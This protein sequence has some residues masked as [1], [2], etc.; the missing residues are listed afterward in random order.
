M[1]NIL[2]FLL[3]LIERQVIWLYVAC[4]LL[5]LF[6][7]RSY[8]LARK[9]RSNTLFTIEREVAAHRE[10]QAMSSIGAIL[11]AAVIIT[12]LR[13]YVVPSVD[14]EG[15]IE[16][17][18]TI[19]LAIPT[20]PTA[21]PTAETPT[22]SPRPRPTRRP[23]RTTAPATPTPLPPPPCPDPDT[24]ISSPRM[25]AI[26]S[27]VVIIHGTATHG[28]FQ[29]YKVEIGRGEEPTAWHV[30]SDIHEAPVINGVLDEFETT[31][32]PDGVYC[33]QLTVVDQT[34]NFPP[35]CRVRLIIQ[36]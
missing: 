16:P 18:A 13:Y 11:G 23:V 24:C 20:R 36:N 8:V 26:V 2:V 22:P 25:G 3:N 31:A 6:Y 19:V 12:A 9:D 21:T 35:P 10:G 15:L 32:V 29:F 1:L 34:G 17:T 4:F 27:G 28:R 33:L 5:I 7:A 14:V 30:V